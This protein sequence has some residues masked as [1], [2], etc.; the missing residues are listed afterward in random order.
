[1]ETIQHAAIKRSD[2]RISKAKSHADVIRQSPDGTCK[3]GSTQGFVTSLNRFVDRDEALKI[4]ID[5]G[6][7]DPQLR[8]IRKMGLL[9][10]NIWLDSNFG[11]HKEIGYYSLDDIELDEQTKKLIFILAR[12]QN[13]WTHDNDGSDL[14]KSHQSH[15]FSM[16][17]NDLPAAINGD[18]H[19]IRT[20]KFMS[21]K[22][23]NEEWEIKKMMEDKCQFTSFIKKVKE[24]KYESKESKLIKRIKKLEGQIEHWYKPWERDARGYLKLLEDNRICSYCGAKDAMCCCPFG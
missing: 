11:Y 16:I 5:S 3:E 14:M 9:S 6:Q 17:F 20:T 22:N 1:M 21:D 24:S 23:N 8:T 2:K 12:I 15:L 19:P 18:N 7:I 10:E 13:C 4:A